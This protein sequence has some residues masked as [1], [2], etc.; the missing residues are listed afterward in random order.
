MKLLIIGGKKFLGYHVAQEAVKRGH[1]VTLFN[2]GKTYPELLPELP[3]IIGDRNTDIDRLAN[4]QFDAVIDTCAYFP[5]QVEQAVK[6]LGDNIKK[7]QLVSTISACDNTVVGIDEDGP[8][9]GLD[10]E[11]TEITGETYGPLKAACEKQLT[12]MLGDK[13]LLIRPGFIVG[14]RDHTDRFSYWP[15]MMHNHNEMIVPET[16]DLKIQ[17][18]DVRD[19]AIFMIDA[20]EKDLSG[21]YHLTGPVE[22]L[23][24]SNFIEACHKTINENCK[25]IKVSDEWLDNNKIVKHA[26]FPL[27]IELKEFAGLHKVNINK[28]INAGLKTRAIEDTLKSTLAWYQEYKGDVSK[29]AAGMKPSDMKELIEKLN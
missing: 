4:M 27:C 14:D 18:I 23:N 5:K 2:R 19:L 3:T 15:V 11:S 21:I 29:L 9:C 7:Y 28:A 25:L 22:P 1:Q 24:F 17:F 10:F 26:A 8:I 6:V 12:D 13:G 16:N 20:L